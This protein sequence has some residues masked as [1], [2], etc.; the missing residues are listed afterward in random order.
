MLIFNMFRLFHFRRLKNGTK[1]GDHKRKKPVGISNR[2]LNSVSIQLNY[3]ASETTSVT[4]GT[5]RFNRFS[6]PDFSVTV[7]DGQ[8]LHE[9]RS[10]TV[11]TPASNER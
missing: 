6:I 4:S 8:P 1:L 3:N 2:L 10:S 5:I 7:D 11:T 9:P